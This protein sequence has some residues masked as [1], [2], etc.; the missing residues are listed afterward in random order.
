MG[1]GKPEWS[2]EYAR[3]RLLDRF[4]LRNM[5]K[6]VSCKYTVRDCKYLQVRTGSDKM[7]QQSRES[8]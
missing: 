5:S 3:Y 8:D 7:S 1:F 4:Y 6:N 2:M